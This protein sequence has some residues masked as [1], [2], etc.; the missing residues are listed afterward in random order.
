VRRGF[1]RGADSHQTLDAAVADSDARPKRNTSSRSCGASEHCARE[2]RVRYPAA[3]KTLG[4]ECAR[5]GVSHDDLLRPK[6][7]EGAGRCHP[8]TRQVRTK[9]GRKP[10]HQI[11]RSACGSRRTT[12]L[13]G[14]ARLF[15]SS[16]QVAATGSAASS[17]DFPSAGARH[18]DRA[19][20]SVRGL[21]EW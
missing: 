21:L 14:R 9:T 13:G 16:G 3:G 11:D 18:V 7:I 19:M 20:A 2:A 17:G 15:V 6:S 4:S 1:C 12:S 10:E 5:V 8:R